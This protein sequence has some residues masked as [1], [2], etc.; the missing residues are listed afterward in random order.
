MNSGPNG[1]KRR[2]FDCAC[3]RRIWE[4]LDASNRRVVEVEEQAAERRDSRSVASLILA[5]LEAG[6]VVST[7]ASLSRLEAAYLTAAP[8]A[9]DALRLR[10]ATEHRCQADLLREIFGNPFRPVSLDPAWATACA[11]GLA[12]TAYDERILPAG[13]LDP[14]CL[15]ILADALEE[16]G[17]HDA[18]ILDHLRGPGPHVRGCWVMDAVLATERP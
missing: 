10:G 14:I 16:A 2:L 9:F 4:L 17:C 6:P 1:R 8:Y 7:G 18:A 15:A 13:Y 3:G 11:K 12:Q 5:K